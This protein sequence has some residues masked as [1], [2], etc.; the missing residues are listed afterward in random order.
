[1]KLKIIKT[2]TIIS[3]LLCGLLLCGCNMAT[4]AMMGIGP[5]LRGINTLKDNH[6]KNIEI[7]KEISEMN[8]EEVK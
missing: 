1:M 6:K 4:F 2:T 7:E 8:V 5:S 3:T